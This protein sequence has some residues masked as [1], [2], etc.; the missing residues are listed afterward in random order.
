MSSGVWVAEAR[1]ADG[2]SRKGVRDASRVGGTGRMPIAAFRR[3][4]RK[5]TREG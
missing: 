5:P 4:L 3:G 1:K 2:Q